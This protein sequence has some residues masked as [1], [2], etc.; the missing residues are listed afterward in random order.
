MA[1]TF[2]QVDPTNRNPSAF[3]EF[4]STNSLRGLQQIQRKALIIAQKTSA[5]TLADNT[6]ALCRNLDEAKTLGGEGS[7]LADIF[8]YWNKNNKNIETQVIAVPDAG[9][10]QVQKITVSVSGTVEAG[11]IASYIGG[12]RLAINVASADSAVTIATN[13]TAEIN[14]NTDLLYT[15]SVIE[16]SNVE[17]TA[18]N[19]GEWTDF[20]NVSFNYRSAE[21]GGNEKFPTGLNLTVAKTTSGAGNPDITNAIAGI[22]DERFDF[23][24]QPYNDDA[25]MDL[26]DAELTNRNDAMVQLEGH[27]FNAKGGS[28]STVGTAGNLRNNEHNTT[29]DAGLNMYS[30]EHAWAGAYA[31]QGATSATQDVARPWQGLEL[32]GILPD[33]EEDRRTFNDRNTLMY[34]GI[35]THNVSSSG[36]VRINRGVTNYQ[37]NSLD[38]P[39][40]S[41]LDS[42]TALTASYCRITFNQWMLTKFPRHKLADD[43]AVF[44]AGQFIVTPKIAKAET[45]AWFTELEQ[46]GILENV[47]QFKADLIVERNDVD[48]NRLDFVL[49]VDFVNQMRIFAS[50]LSFILN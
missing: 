2:S 34:D 26:W 42:M 41:W 25:N 17:L 40:A 32:V 35:A 48:P 3:M 33:H 1:I 13:I 10:S 49:P 44:S 39:D 5:G 46:A 8:D 29:M 6:I 28:V 18:K 22:P 47:A 43:T 14:A 45:I 23:I 36:A 4:D 7:Q 16:T 24:I 31:G 15:A 37:K 27:S 38:Q 12:R 9:T 21:Y 19:G 50:R 20:L 30:P 11:V